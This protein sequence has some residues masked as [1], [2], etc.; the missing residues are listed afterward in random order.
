MLDR[1]L[2]IK[3]H[4]QQKRGGKSAKSHNSSSAQCECCLQTTTWSDSFFLSF[5][6]T[7]KVRGHNGGKTEINSDRKWI[8]QKHLQKFWNEKFRKQFYLFTCIL[9]DYTGHE[10]LK[11]FWKNSHFEN[12]RAGFLKGVKTHFGKLVLKLCI[13]RHEKNFLTNI[14][15]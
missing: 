1:S 14:M 4:I 5:A 3:S 15:S 9:P 11:E 12:M 8:W 10:S 7:Y 13:F 6:D 2:T